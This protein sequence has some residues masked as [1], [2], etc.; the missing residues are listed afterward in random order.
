MGISIYRRPYV[1][2]WIMGSSRFRGHAPLML[3]SLDMSAAVLPA[4]HNNDRVIGDGDRGVQTRGLWAIDPVTIYTQIAIKW[5]IRCLLN[6]IVWLLFSLRRSFSKG[7]WG[8]L[9]WCAELPGVEYVRQPGG[10]CISRRLSPS[11]RSAPVQPQCGRCGFLLL[12]V[13]GRFVPWNY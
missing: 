3:C 7:S 11:R 12:R 5:E 8:F 9:G 6:L 10:S 2:W 1:C 13:C 4:S